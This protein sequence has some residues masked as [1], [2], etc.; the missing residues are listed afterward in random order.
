MA[1]KLARLA[2]WMLKFG[3]E[4]VYKGAENYEAKFRQQQAPERGHSLKNKQASTEIRS[5]PIE[6]LY[7]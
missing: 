7:D 3:T 6:I 5:V 4:Y 1:Y 2:Y